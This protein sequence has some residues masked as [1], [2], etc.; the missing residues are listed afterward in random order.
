MSGRVLAAGESMT[1]LTPFDPRGKPL[2]FDE[3]N[4]LWVKMNKDRERI[5]VGICYSSTLGG[6]LDL[7]RRRVDTQ[8]HHRDT[9]LPESVGE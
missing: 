6:V 8:H 1:V 2:S 9:T 7:A 4:P 5:T 3:S